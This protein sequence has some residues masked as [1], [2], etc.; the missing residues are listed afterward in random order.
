MSAIGWAETNPPGPVSGGQ[1]GGD[2]A[3]TEAYSRRFYLK[4]QAALWLCADVSFYYWQKGASDGQPTGPVT[5]E[6]E[7]EF[8]AIEGAHWGSG[9]ELFADVRSATVGVCTGEPTLEGARAACAAFD[10]VGL[11]GWDGKE[12][13]LP[14]EAWSF[15][16]IEVS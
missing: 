2:D 11:P 12:W 4:V 16:A 1:C 8:F 13:P 14:A 9:S 7:I 10:P 15:G 5:L 6:R 3:V